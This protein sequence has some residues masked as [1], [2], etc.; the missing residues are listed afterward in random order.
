M[1]KTLLQVW[2]LCYYLSETDH[3]TDDD[4]AALKDLELPE[5][6]V[7]TKPWHNLLFICSTQVAVKSTDKPSKQ[8]STKQWAIQANL[9]NNF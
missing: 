6:E 2:S 1:D 8:K 7:I 4:D 9:G 3:I 5:A